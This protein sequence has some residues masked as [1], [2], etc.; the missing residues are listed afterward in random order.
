M[1]KRMIN[2]HPTQNRMARQPMRLGCGFM[3]RRHGLRSAQ[4]GR[5]RSIS[6]IALPARRGRTTSEGPE[7]EALLAAEELGAVAYRIAVVGDGS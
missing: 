3:P 6:R 2:G 4:G 1:I 5:R 7:L